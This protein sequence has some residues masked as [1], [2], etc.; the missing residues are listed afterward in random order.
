MKTSE[1]IADL[2]AA[3]SIAQGEMTGAVKGSE[4]PFFKSKYADLSSVI[5][6]IKEPFSKNGLSYLQFPITTTNSIGEKF[7]GTVT[8][9]MHSSGEW[10]ESEYFLPLLKNDPQSVGSAITYA[11]R[12]SLQAAAGI[13]AED[14]DGEKAM[15]RNPKKQRM[16][17][18]KQVAQIHD[19]LEQTE[20]NLEHFLKV[21]KKDSV[22]N[23]TEAD[24]AKALDLI[25]Q[26][27]ER[28]GPDASK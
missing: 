14:D 16:I 15:D 2:A 7:V 3:L 26:K 28:R 12:Y 23:F 9:I 13:P 25:D 27:I 5:A 11:R 22:D 10:I 19:L 20:S 6:A 18:E 21:F 17:S 4:N 24:Y 8:R 1:S